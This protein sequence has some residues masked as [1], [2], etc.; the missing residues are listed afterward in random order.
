MRI[1]VT[2]AGLGA[3]AGGPHDRDS[4]ESLEALGIAL[5]GNS[6]L[7]IGA[8]NNGGTRIEQVDPCFFP[9]MLR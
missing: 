8:G 4:R 3:C 9:Y 6:R 5:A 1:A 7:K 2:S